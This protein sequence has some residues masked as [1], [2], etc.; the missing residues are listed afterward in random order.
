M[1]SN[2]Y[3]G[4]LLLFFALLLI[5]SY[6][7]FQGHDYLIS[8]QNYDQFEDLT[9]EIDS[10]TSGDFTIPIEADAKI[11]FSF[12]TGS[13]PQISIYVVCGFFIISNLALVLALTSF[14]FLN[15]WLYYVGSL[16]VLLAF[17]FQQPD[18]LF[19]NQWYSKFILVAPIVLLGGTSYYFFAISYKTSF[20]KRFLGISAITIIY[21]L[22]I[23]LF[24]QIEF[25]VLHLANYGSLAF[26]VISIGFIFLVSFEIV[27]LFLSLITNSKGARTKTGTL[28]F[29]LIYVLY[30][31]NLLLQYLKNRGVIHFDLVFISPFIILLVSSIAGIWGFK[32]RSEMFKITLPFNP[33]GGMIYISWAILTAAS[34]AY[35]FYSGNDPLIEVFEDTI[36][37]THIG[38][39]FGFFLYVGWNYSEWINTQAQ[40]NKMIYSYRWVS[41][42][43]VYAIGL[44]AV[45]SLFFY[46]NMF[47][48]RQFQAGYHNYLG[49][50]YYNSNDLQLA[51]RYYQNAESWEFQNHKTNF[52]LATIYQKQNRLSEALN[53]YRKANLKQPSAYAYANL[54]TMKY[55]Q[56]KE[57]EAI[58]DLKDGLNEFPK[59][60]ALSIN[61]GLVY[62]R[63]HFPDSSFHYFSLAQNDAKFSSF[64]HSN[65]KALL[66]KYGIDTKDKE[67]I[68]TLKTKAKQRIINELAHALVMKK[69][70]EKTS[71]G[72]LLT[73][74]ILTEKDFALVNNF[75]LH[76][77]SNTHDSLSLIQLNKWIASDSN[78]I[79]KTDLLYIKAIADYY[80]NQP[81]EAA[82]AVDLLQLSHESE[83]GKYLN[84]LGL[85]ALEQK[86]GRFA[87]QIFQH[88]AAKGFPSA[89][90][91]KAIALA[92]AGQFEEMVGTLQNVKT[93]SDTSNSKVLLKL[94]SLTKPLKFNNLLIS[95]D[96][97]KASF[98][99]YKG[100]NLS[101]SK[102]QNLFFSITDKKLRLKAGLAIFD[103]YAA[104]K[105]IFI[106]GEILS[107][108]TKETYSESQLSQ[109]NL[110]L[111]HYLVM[112][113][114]VVELEKAI[115][116][117]KLIGKDLIYLPYFEAVAAE[118]K[119]EKLLAEAKYSLAVR[120]CAFNEPV[121]LQA[122]DFFSTKQVNHKLAFN[123]L[124]DGVAMNPYSIKL[125]KAYCLES[126]A[127]GIP[128]FG[129]SGLESLKPLISNKEFEAFK[130]TF[131][132]AREQFTKE[133][134]GL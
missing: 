12:L 100:R 70:V 129:E 108:L 106:C 29:V 40:V 92:D 127:F 14:T 38:F 86:N 112:K 30:T 101:N 72:D 42:L 130:K 120:N 34:I 89:I 58:L 24:S 37:F 116:S 3:L 4:S 20:T 15:N 43:T 32:E 115:Q 22:G 36:L 51:E 109:L 65:Q 21:F 11:V 107:E 49:D 75:M 64:A 26:M 78:I 85:W 80:R 60:G 39:G 93:D 46:S 69:N 122:A 59:S 111:L 81:F 41:F 5:G 76:S 73:D 124:L 68:L 50:I 28:Q 48:Y 128:S 17:V 90:L 117:H 82:K 105:D 103:I 125:W 8:W 53:H 23:F 113:N 47:I 83:A 79:Y 134:L 77:K 118:M 27:Y 123:I 45:L 61:L 16:V 1:A 121:L 13:A 54:A 56:G 55:L 99:Y 2:I 44:L 114:E 133:L 35:C 131:D 95:D 102:R 84:T 74:T 126:V 31:A 119:D 63:I 25:T 52:S 57:I 9:L 19:Y 71:L 10:F 94:I 88:A 67:E 96:E 66:A 33:L 104:Q 97:T 62:E 6:F 98:L 91:N 7:V 18:I 132:N 110:K 87:A